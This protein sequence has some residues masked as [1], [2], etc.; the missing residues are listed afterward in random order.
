MLSGNRGDGD[1]GSLE[2]DNYWKVQQWFEEDG[3]DNENITVEQLGLFKYRMSP[4][5]ASWLCC[6]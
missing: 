5:C 6:M 4:A 3:G 1:S 2:D